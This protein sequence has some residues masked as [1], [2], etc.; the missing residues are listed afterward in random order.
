MAIEEIRDKLK[1]F[2]I[3]SGYCNPE[4]TD[5]F[6]KNRENLMKSQKIGLKNKQN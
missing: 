6:Q 3:S 1:N 2:K 5:I 4:A